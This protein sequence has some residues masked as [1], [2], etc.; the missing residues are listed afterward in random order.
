M[1]K[2]TF[3]SILFSILLF[4]GC[5]GGGSSPETTVDN[6]KDD[7]KSYLREA[8][9]K[10]AIKFLAQAS[11]GA[12]AS[13]ISSV[14]SKGFVGWIDEQIQMPHTEDAVAQIMKF[15]KEFDPTAYPL[16]VAEYMADDANIFNSYYAARPS[17]KYFAMFNLSIWAR[18]AL[19]GKEQLRHRMAY[20]LSQII[21]VSNATS[22]FDRRADGLTAYYEILSKHAFGNYKALLKEISHHPSMGIYLTYLGNKKAE[23]VSTPDENYAREIM[24]LFTIGLNELNIDG[25]PKL[26]GKGQEI[27]TYTQEDIE[28][29]SRVFTGWDMAQSGKYGKLDGDL[30]QPMRFNSQYHDE[31]NKTVLGN[32]INGA[33]DQ[34]INNAIDMLFAHANV[35]PFV[36]KLLIKR[37]TTSNPS[38]AYV[39]RVATIF[40]DNGKGEKG[41]LEAV[42]KAILLDEEVRGMSTKGDIVKVKEPLLA[43]TQLLRAFDVQGFK[44]YDSRFNTQVSGIWIADQTKYF[45][46]SPMG[47]ETVFNYYSPEYTPADNEFITKPLTSPEIEIQTSQ[48]LVNFSNKIHNLFFEHGDKFYE[49]QILTREKN[50]MTYLHGSVEAF[51]IFDRGRHNSLKSV[52]YDDKFYINFDEEFDIFEMVIDG[53]SNRDFQNINVSTTNQN[54]ETPKQEGL[55]ALIEHLDLKLTAKTMTQEQKDLIIAYLDTHINDDNQFEE[56]HRCISEAIRAIVTT[57]T[58]MVQ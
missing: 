55:K 3:G 48:V 23:G 26:D 53:D 33:G 11:F 27:A 15:A 38:P 36:S 37:L 42:L 49:S 44:D 28:E 34:E 12:T 32:T 51:V 29:L 10:E 56:A 47:A 24:Q 35:A 14:K 16:S 50:Y 20:A 22:I 30:H 31:G 41:D 8:D 13:E 21:V 2:F 9:D 19:Q 45:G 52:I 6:S 25:T 7:S 18:N 43:Y 58:Y 40:N 17:N 57:S 46:Q 5:G 39:A 54:G 1:N 4:M